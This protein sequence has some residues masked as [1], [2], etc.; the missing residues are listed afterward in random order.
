MKN[1]EKVLLSGLSVLEDY[2]KQG[3]IPGGQIAF[4]TKDEAGFNHAGYAQTVD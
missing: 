2:I 1:N 4:V 3:K